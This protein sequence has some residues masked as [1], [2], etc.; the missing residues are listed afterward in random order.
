MK[1]W[2]NKILFAVGIVMAFYLNAAGATES[3]RMVPPKKPTVIEQRIDSAK[4]WAIGFGADVKQQQIENMKTTREALRKDWS[5]SEGGRL[6]YRLKNE[7]E[8]IK[9]YQRQQNQKGRE[10]LEANKAQ[11]QDYWQTVADALAKLGLKPVEEK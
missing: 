6:T 4:L 11:L 5:W 9:A 10:Q 2:E 8:D 3:N 1:T 7:W